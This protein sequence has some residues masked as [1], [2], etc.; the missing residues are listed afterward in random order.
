MTIFLQFFDK[1]STKNMKIDGIFTSEVVK[2]LRF[3]KNEMDYVMVPPGELRVGSSC[4]QGRWIP[5]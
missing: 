3:V 2:I 4:V 1:F 5:K